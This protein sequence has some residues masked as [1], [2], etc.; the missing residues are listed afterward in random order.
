M[1]IVVAPAS[2]KGS[3]SA[4]AAADAIAAGLRREWPDAAVSMVPLADGGEGTLDA[5]ARARTARRATY[6]VDDADGRA[7][8]ADYLWLDDAVAV[9]E[10]A[11]VVRFG[12]A[13]RPLRARSSFG[14][15]AL[16]RHTLDQGSRRVIVGL[17]GTSTN[18]GGAGLLAALGVRFYAA[19]RE[20]LHPVPQDLLDLTRIDFSG[21]DARV[22]A[23]DIV[24]LTDVA[25]PLLGANGAS[26]VYG[27][28]KGAT[29]DDVA[30]L[31]RALGHFA[32]LC[33]EA[34]GID[35][36]A[37]AGSGAAGGLGY[38]LQ[39]LG[40]QRYSGAEFIADLA[41]LDRHLYGAEIAITGE[42]RADRQTLQGKAPALLA[43]HA[44]QAGVPSWLLAGNIAN[45][46][47]ADLER[48]FAYCAALIDRVSEVD[49][50][51]CAA[52]ALTDLA[53]DAARHWRRD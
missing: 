40:V 19:G 44:A 15:G 46:V 18:D 45:D 48:Q 10:A 38:A 27:P 50:M 1:K 13:K 25:N 9:I 53:Q 20:V 28:Q 43:R 22:S 16:L 2:F 39:L 29:P 36:S 52:V 41:G 47:R 24:V 17:G 11:Q 14:I 3:L 21:V 34:T 26:A 33:H 35:A 8:H 6:T 51:T 37:A 32:S 7:V 31:D 4:P 30:A 12:A 5:I 23:G 42:G 49:A